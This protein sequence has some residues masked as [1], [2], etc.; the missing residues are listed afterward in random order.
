[1]TRYLRLWFALGKFG[2]LREMA[3]RG[4]FLARLAVEVLWF[5]I[6]LIFYDAIFAQTAGNPVAGWGRY[7][8]YFFVGCYFALGGLIET[9]FLSNCGEFADLVRSGDLDFY[10]LKPIDEQ[11][12]LTCRDLDW[13]TAPNV[14][15]GA[16]L[17][18]FALLNMPAWTFDPLLAGLFLA[19]FVCGLGMA[20]SFLLLLM[21]TSVWLVRNQ[22]LYELWWLFTTLMR[23]PR[24]IFRGSWELVGRLFTYVIPIMVATNVP[25]NVM[26][27]RLL[28]PVLVGYTFAATAALLYLSRK[29]F[30]LA[31]RRYRSASS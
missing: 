6:M 15:M 12:L 1:M 26:A 4:N 9:L 7:E 11:F 17:M 31:L 28:D 27:K 14:L 24:E 8:Y 22:S 2:L 13:A 25:A 19:L 21:S 18:V 23:Y 16:G 5:G 29:F 3:F 20:Y 30:R 10:L